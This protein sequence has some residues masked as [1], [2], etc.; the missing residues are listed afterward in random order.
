MHIAKTVFLL[1]ICICFLSSC[2]LGRER[3]DM[4]SENNVYKKVDA[5]LEQIIESIETR[6]NEKIKSMFSEQALNEA[7]ELDEG[8]DYLFTLIEGSIQSWDRVGG[9]VDETNDYGRKMVKARLRYNVY[10][11][12]EQYL[13]SILEYTE[14]AD[15]PE[16]IG[17]YNIKAI[18]VNSEEPIFSEAGIYMPE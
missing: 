8:I 3:K 2:S 15:H 16:N 7:K 14:D 17:V 12:K 5:H 18:N 13:F 11:D 1:L 9:S 6:D 10:T 4:D